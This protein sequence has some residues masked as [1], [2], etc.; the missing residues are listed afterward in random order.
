MDTIVDDVETAER[1][2][3]ALAIWYDEGLDLFAALDAAWRQQRELDRYA[4]RWDRG[5]KAE[6]VAAGIELMP[7]GDMLDTEGM[8]I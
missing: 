3:L 8:R 7:E 1:L 4:A 5:A 6:R 2:D